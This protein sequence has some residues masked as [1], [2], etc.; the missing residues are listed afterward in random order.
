[1]GTLPAAEVSAI[2]TASAAGFLSYPLGFLGKSS[3]FAAYAAHEMLPICSGRPA[4]GV[5]SGAPFW[6]ARSAF[7]PASH[8]PGIAAAARTWYEGH[9]LA[10]QAAEIAA[11]V[12]RAG[13]APR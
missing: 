12:T 4:F 9:S 3:V 7:S 8:A 11:W 5:R 2:L 10:R 6:D 1:M 13:G